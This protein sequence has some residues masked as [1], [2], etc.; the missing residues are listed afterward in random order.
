MNVSRKIPEFKV[1]SVGETAV[2]KTSIIMRFQ[3]NVFLPEH[4]ATVGASYITKTVE[5]PHGQAN[6]MLW[7]TAGQERYRSL[8]P[9]YAR[10]AAVALIVFDVSEKATFEELGNWVEA[11]R[12]DAPDDCSLFIVGNKIDL[13]FAVDKSD[14]QRWAHREKVKLMFVSALTGEGINELF[15]EVANV[16]P[17]RRYSPAVQEFIHD[18]NEKKGDCC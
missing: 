4:Q 15:N 7:D 11:V 5:T 10:S 17:T 18:G 3:H 6:L 2:G 9:M 12:Q 8:V 13:P 14:V 1:I 16:L